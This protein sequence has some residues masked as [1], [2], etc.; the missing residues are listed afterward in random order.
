MFTLSRALDLEANQQL[1]PPLCPV[2]FVFLIFHC[3]SVQRHPQLL[4]GGSEMLGGMLGSFA[5]SLL[6]Q[7][8]L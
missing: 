7:I 2:F 6:W 4:H 8:L 5:M 3:S 1:S